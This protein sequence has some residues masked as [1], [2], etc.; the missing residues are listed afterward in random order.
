MARASRGDAGQA[1][2]RAAASLTR[3]RRIAGPRWPCCW[4]RRLSAASLSDSLPRSGEPVAQTARVGETP[5]RCRPALVLPGDTRT[6]RQASI[7]VKS[8][9]CASQV[10]RDRDRRVRSASVYR[11]GLEESTTRASGSPSVRQPQAIAKAE[12][13]SGNAARA[14]SERPPV[15]MQDAGTGP[16]GGAAAPRPSR[17]RLAFGSSP[18]ALRPEATSKLNGREPQLAL[19][20]RGTQPRALQRLKAAA[21]GR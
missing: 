2:P 19:T 13:V 14:G 18:T 9:L 7:R 3:T 21:R 10:P 1:T 16:A 15:P 17:Q 20:A 4:Q 6:G 8:G 12:T 11:R 5:T